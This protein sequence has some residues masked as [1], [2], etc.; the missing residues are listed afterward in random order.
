MLGRIIVGSAVLFSLAAMAADASSPELQWRQLGPF[1]GGWATVVA[2]VPTQPDKFYFGAAGGG[3]WETDDAGH[4]WRA[5]FEHGPAASIGA[6]AVSPSNPNV[7]YVGTGQP[8]TRYDLG[9]GEGVFKSVDG[10][11]NWISLGLETTR[12]IGRI[13][14]DPKNPDV[15]IVGAQGHFFGPSADRGIYRSTDGG[16][17]WTHAL[18]IDGWTGVVDVASDPQDS[19]IIF[20][21]AWE[22]HQYPWLGYF[23][24]D[25]G[26]RQRALQIDRRRQNLAQACGRRLADRHAR[27]HRSCRHAYAQDHARLCRRRLERSAGLYRSD[28]GGAH[29]TRVNDSDKFTSSYASRLTVAPDNPDIVY[30]VGQ[31]I[32]RC[33]DGGKDCEIVKGAPGGDDYH[34]IWINP[35]HP[36]HMITGSDQGAAVSVNGGATWSGLVQS[37]DRTILS[38]GSRQPL[39]LLDL[40]RPAG[41]RHGRHR[42]PQRLRAIDLSRLASG[43]R[44]RARLRRSRSR[45]SAD[46]LRQRSRWTRHQMGCDTPDRSPT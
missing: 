19:K 14:V 28:D 11:K 17:T 22:A 6:L 16:K 1:R 37:A 2:G 35:L 4:T 8:E 18:A 45:R 41:Q 27:T 30:T 12:H 21:A 39:S 5:I 7:L 32:R 13:W 46:R 44:R 25:H 36:D 43:R 42:Q 40:F 29:W 9:A 38:S 3:V 15:V 31:S 24:P 23:M 34:H 20:A 33:V 26:T 10:G